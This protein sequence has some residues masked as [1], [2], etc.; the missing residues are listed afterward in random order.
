[1][2]TV[3]LRV[4]SWHKTIIRLRYCYKVLIGM[5]TTLKDSERF[6]TF[7]ARHSVRSWTG[8]APKGKEPKG[9]LV[10]PPDL[11]PFFVLTP[12]MLFKDSLRR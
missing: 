4:R 9:Q 8:S 3:G 11:D 5:L 7:M 2:L 12:S 1:M 6:N 10:H